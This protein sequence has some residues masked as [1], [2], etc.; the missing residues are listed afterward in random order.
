M[1][2][3]S[4]EARWTKALARQFCPVSSYFLANYHRLRPHPNARGLTSTEAM[5]I[6]QLIDHKWDD[7]APYP[8]LRTLASRMGLSVRGVRNALQSLSE[9]GYVRRELSMTGGP[10]RYHLDGL[11]KALEALMADDM[12]ARGGVE[13][14][15]AEPPEAPATSEAA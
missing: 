3:Q 8:T 13:A 10:T 12:L 4:I 2:K 15:P 7:R 14:E 5:L 1:K 9:L 11:N 6:I